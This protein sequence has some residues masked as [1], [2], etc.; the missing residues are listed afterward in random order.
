MA[1]QNNERR[2][3]VRRTVFSVL[4]IT[5]L[6]GLP[7]FAGPSLAAEK[8]LVIGGVAFLTGPGAAGGMAAKAGWELVVDKYNKA[9]G[10]KVGNDTYKIKLIVEDDAMAVDQAATAATKLI[11]SD[12]AKFI[13]GPLNDDLKNAVY[14]IA[15]KAGVMMAITDGV[16]VSRALPFDHNADVGP[17]KPLY[18]RMG[19]SSDEIYPFLL[20]YLQEHYPN[21]KKIAVCGVVERTEDF[22]FADMKRKLPPRGLQIVGNH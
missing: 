9:G 1:L 12:G 15:R 8:T 10:L 13:V 18:M 14:Q 22:M 3:A 16:N 19:W 2:I 21:A 7:I 5:T 4:L 17:E 11:K 20:D 6:L